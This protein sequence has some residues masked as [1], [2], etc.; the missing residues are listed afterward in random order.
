MTTK[1]AISQRS[2]SDYWPPCTT[3]GHIMENHYPKAFGFVRRQPGLPMGVP[4]PEDYRASEEECEI[5]PPKVPQVWTACFGTRR[6]V[7]NPNGSC[8]CKGYKRD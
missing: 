2:R 4:K 8:L 3:C 5:R 7:G 1:P 6:G